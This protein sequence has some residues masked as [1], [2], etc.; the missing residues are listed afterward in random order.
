MVRARPRRGRATSLDC[1][2]ILGEIEEAD[3]SAAGAHAAPRGPLGVTASVMFG[4]LYVA[5]ILFDFVGRYPRVVARA[6]LVDRLV[7]MMEEGLDVAV[8][9]AHLPSSNLVPCGWDRCGAWSA[10]RRIILPGMACRARSTIS[11]AMTPSCSRPAPPRRDW[12]FPARGRSVAVRPRAQLVVN[13]VEVAVAGAVAG[14]GL[15]RA[16]L[17]GRAGADG[18]TVEGRA[19]GLRA[20]AGA[21]ACRACGGAT[22]NARVRAFVDFAVERLR[23]DKALQ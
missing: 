20:A 12:S 8:R 4:R 14:H 3:S 21:D 18:G 22:G 5:P 10:P 15:T 1:R 13:T 7:D 16:L 6:L 11:N 2:R 17:P 9:I 19:G 23:A